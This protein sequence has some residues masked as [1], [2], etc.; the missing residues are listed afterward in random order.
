MKRSIANITPTLKR[1]AVA[2]L[3][4]LAA[5]ALALTTACANA[6]AASDA[7]DIVDTPSQSA[8]T[9]QSTQSSQAAQSTQTSPT[10]AASQP[11]Q[12]A[13]STQE[14]AL[15]TSWQ[16]PA[17]AQ[18]GATAAPQS[19]Q[20]A[21]S[22]AADAA[23]PDNGAPAS[24]TTTAIDADTIV[25]AFEQVISGV[26]ADVIPS[27]VNIIVIDRM[28]AGSMPPWL[29]RP[30]P[31]A[32]Q[33]NPDDRSDDNQDDGAQPQE[34]FFFRNG[35]GSGFVW[36]T[37]GHIVTNHHVVEDAHRILVIFSDGAEAYAE[38]IGADPAA[39]LA[40]LK[41][42]PAADALT[43]VSLGDSNAVQVGQLAIAIGNPFGQEFTTTIGI[44]SAVGRTIRSGNTPF[45]VPKIIQ[46][47]AP[48]NPGNSG[49]PLLDR[50]GN[51]IGINAQIV[52]G[53]G[54][55]AG[56]GFAIPINTAKQIVPA[57]IDDGDF[58]YSWLG[59]RGADLR[60]EAAE[61]MGADPATQG[62]LVIDLAPDGPA[63]Q[64]GLLGS[65]ELERTDD[66]NIQ[67]GGD[68]IIAVDETPIAGMDDLIIYLLENTMPG[69]TVTMSVI[70]NGGDA[71]SIRVTLAE[72]P[73]TLN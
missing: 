60:P 69:D 49:G 47:D 55:N 63:E 11:S 28:E 42:D 29:N 27:V 1:P 64:A 31:F 24:E 36:D 67:Y 65:E 5:I 45:S 51:V 13:Q 40:V 7:V 59:I 18:S 44:V 21:Q 62:A 54:S 32:P 30:F 43:P 53:T 12:P 23:N 15:P 9:A 25:A 6:P 57:L 46:T 71:A 48:I 4:A 3:I 73:E 26:H 68:V 19:R 70:R 17:E 66:G 16:P 37:H 8:S 34:D 2:A 41:I 20:P 58:K 33:P 61:L 39:D 72:R 50:R 10:D 35:Q 52:T 14:Q 56:V 22:H 38:V